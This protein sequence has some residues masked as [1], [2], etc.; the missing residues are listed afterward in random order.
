MGIHDIFATVELFEFEL[1]LGVELFTGVL[2]DS[3]IELN[4]SLGIELIV[5]SIRGGVVLV[6]LL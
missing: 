3:L 5:S 1:G 4:L 2:I 6:L